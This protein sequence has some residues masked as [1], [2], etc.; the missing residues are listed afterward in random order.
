LINGPLSLVFCTSPSIFS[1]AV[2]K[3]IQ[4]AQGIE[5]VGLVYSSRI[6][7]KDEGW[8]EGGLRMIRQS[9]L[10]YAIC[11]FMQTH[12]FTVIRNLLSASSSLNVPILETKNIN[13]RQG[14]AFIQCLDPDVILL[15]HFNQIVS[16]EIFDVPT[17]ACLNIHPSL[18]PDYKGVD[19]VFSALKN[20]EL[21]LGV[22]VH[23]VSDKVDSGN[24]LG[25]SEIEVSKGK[26]LFHHQ[27]K[28]FDRGGVLATEL[29]P[30][31][32]HGPQSKPQPFEGNYASW[33]TKSQIKE[34]RTQG[35]KLIT[36]LD[37]LEGFRGHLLVLCFIQNF[38]LI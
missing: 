37:Y 17:L 31:L 16:S 22:T 35:G 8:V 32:K 9:G 23:E 12:F 18:L 21:R 3:S 25:Q 14:V 15:A 34:F 30:K 1:Q 4:N 36:L 11:Q 13:N 29:I 33:P 2:L 38:S 27:L 6:F 26:S 24:I 19:P 5:V 20:N 7:G 28:L 10:S